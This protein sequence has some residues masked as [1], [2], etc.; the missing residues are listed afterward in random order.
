MLNKLIRF[1][2]LILFIFITACTSIPEIPTPIPT[3]TQI[4]NCSATLDDG[5][6]P[7]YVPNTPERN[8]VGT[9][10]VITGVVL[11]SLDCKP[12][13]NAKL[14]FDASK[15]ALELANANLFK[16]KPGEINK[17]YWEDLIRLKK[18]NLEWI[19]QNPTSKPKQ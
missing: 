14:E 9:E 8:I 1:L 13:A 12:I 10:H 3:N 17:Q 16:S 4:K 5:I 18:N 11:S 2:I 6:S 7:S 19:Q 15:W